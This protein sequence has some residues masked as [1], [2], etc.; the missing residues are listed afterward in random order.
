MYEFES[1][2]RAKALKL[3]SAAKMLRQVSCNAFVPEINT[4][5]LVVAAHDDVVTRSS[6]I[7]IDDLKRCPSA[8]VALYEKGGHCDFFFSK[9]SRKTGKFYHK[10]YMPEPT[11]AF[12]QAVD[13]A[14]QTLATE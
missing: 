7:P 13:R 3:K 8:L 5:L 11:F 2:T 14:T 6:R 12:F 1:M 9:K 4:P 10:E